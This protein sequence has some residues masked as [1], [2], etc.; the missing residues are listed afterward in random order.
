MQLLKALCKKISIIS[1]ICLCASCADG[2]VIIALLFG[3]KLNSDKLEFGL[4]GGLNQSYISNFNHTKT[5]SGFNF[6]LY[7]NIKLGDSWFI[8]A[9]AAPKFPTGASKLKPY[10]LN[11][12]NLDS[13]LQ[14][15]DVTRKIK[16]IAL[17]ILMRYRIKNLLFAE[18]GP[19]IDLR[20]K[21]KD[22]FESGNL[23]Y[24]NKIEDNITRFDFGFAFGLTQK[25]NKNIGS[26]AF[27]IRY[28]M[29]I[30]DIDKLTQGSQKNGVIQILAN[31]P[32]G[33]GKQ[34]QKGKD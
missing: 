26:M 34:K 4:A 3:D 17:P 12:S 13:L 27:G 24:K 18:V 22:V 32:V 15:G 5:K 21:A 31:I 11:D 33:A 7:F 28:Y 8:R 2:Q 19:Q 14:N 29:G 6:G 25:L 23:T 9:E 10:S 16:N 20:T 30:T 1:L